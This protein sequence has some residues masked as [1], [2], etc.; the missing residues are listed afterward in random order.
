MSSSPKSGFFGI[1]GKPELPP[2]PVST[3][4][5]TEETRLTPRTAT[6]NGV[7]AVVDTSNQ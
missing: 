4:R 5:R 3:Q 1:H 6:E 7:T 2:R